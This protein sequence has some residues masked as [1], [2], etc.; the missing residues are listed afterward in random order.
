VSCSI[1]S[2]TASWPVPAD[3]AD[4][5]AGQAT[6]EFAVVLPLLLSFVLLV[7][8][9]GLVVRD[10]V[11]V[12]HAARE[13]ARAAAVDGNAEQAASLG[14]RSAGLDP[15]RFVV[16]VRP[17]DGRVT[18]TVRYRSTIVVPLLRRA[19]PAVELS[20]EVTMHDESAAPPL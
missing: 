8:Q 1:E 11:L 9:T 18:A 4:P 2:S 17:H 5:Q 7:V 20:S 16:T 6:A 13:A 10:Q 19:V 3:R 14:A 12:V 15:A